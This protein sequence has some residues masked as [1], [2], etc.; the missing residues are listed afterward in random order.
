MWNLTGVKEQSSFEPIPKG[1]YLVVAKAGELK[2][3]KDGTGKY[4]KVEFEVLEGDFKGRKLWMNFNVQNANPKAVEIALSQMKSFFLA[5]GAKES[6][7]ATLTPDSFAGQSAT[8]VVDLQSD[9]YGEKNV[10]KG[11]KKPTEDGVQRVTQQAKATVKR[12]GL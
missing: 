6:S 1:D 2:A 11:F 5:A 3:T 7:I 9:S 4:C 8:A 12:M 10:I